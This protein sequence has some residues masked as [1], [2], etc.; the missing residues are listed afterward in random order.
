MWYAPSYLLRMGSN[1][2]AEDRVHMEPTQLSQ[3]LRKGQS[4][5]MT[6]R[7]WII[8]LSTVGGAMGQLVTLYQ[9]GV[10]S[11]LPDPPG[12][13]LFDADRVDASNYAYSRFNSPDGSLMTLNYAL[14]AWI[15]SAG[16]IDRA[17][18][19]PIPRQTQSYITDRN[20]R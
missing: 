9:T 20:G 7:R 1:L 13:Q 4:P 18:R 16:G 10:V 8:G 19:N 2:F 11:H 14:T 12:Q 17:R 3:E 6:R 5:D 15:A